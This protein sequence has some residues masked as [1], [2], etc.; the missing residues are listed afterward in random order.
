MLSH[1]DNEEIMNIALMCSNND[2]TFQKVNDFFKSIN[3]EQNINIGLSDEAIK[4]L[5]SQAKKNKLNIFF[6]NVLCMM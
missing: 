6:Q 3:E 4:L 5:S 1:A 2:K